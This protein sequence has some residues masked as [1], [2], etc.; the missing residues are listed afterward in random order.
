MAEDSLS[1]AEGRSIFNFKSAHDP[2]NKTRGHF[3]S[4]ALHNGPALTPGPCD[5]G[6]DPGMTPE[7]YGSEFPAAR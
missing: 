1:E 7:E 6:L 3:S 4:C 2:D 5:C